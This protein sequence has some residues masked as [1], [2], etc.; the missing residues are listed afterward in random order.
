V[1]PRDVIRVGVVG[2]RFGARVQVP[3]FRSDPRCVVTALA[4]RSLDSTAAVAAELDIPGWYA[5]WRALISEG[6]IDALGIA[7][8]PPEQPA[9]IVEA[10]R[11]GKH[12]FCE[13]PLAATVAAAE[14]A[15]ASVQASGVVHAMDFI[16]PEIPAWKRLHDLLSSRTIGA[17]RHFSYVWQVETFAS[18]TKADS[19]KNRSEEGGGVVANFLSHVIFNLEWLLGPVAGIETVRPRHGR[20]AGSFC[21][22]IVHLENR[23]HG[24]VSVSTDAYLGEGHKLTVFG[25]SGT[26]V[27]H[28][29]TADYASGFELRVGTREIGRLGLVIRDEAPSGVDGRI[30][31]VGCIAARFLDGI[32][33]D[34]APM[35]NLADG[36][37][38]Q[39]WIQK[40][41]NDNAG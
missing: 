3:A 17:V 36:L 1:N 24:T 22:C 27:L 21:D 15:V 13:K 31:P 4:G 29:A 40:L 2:L 5:D 25:E 37:R 41:N 26:I 34:I 19:W 7:V 32:R 11:H 12:V 35:P 39:R 10:A 20:S 38:I 16:F 8:P 18:R 30:A 28:N 14:D 9:I 23:I 33:G 6:A